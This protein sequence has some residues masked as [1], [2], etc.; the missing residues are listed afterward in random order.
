MPTRLNEEAAKAVDDRIAAIWEKI[1]SPDYFGK[2]APRSLM[3]DLFYGAKKTTPEALTGGVSGRIASNYIP[4]EIHEKT[5]IGI[6]FSSKGDA[7][8]VAATRRDDNGALTIDKIFEVTRK[9]KPTPQQD[10]TLSPQY[11][12]RL[13]RRGRDLYDEYSTEA[14]H[15]NPRTA[16]GIPVKSN[17]M[18]PYDAPCSPCEGSGSGGDEATYCPRCKGAG[19]TRFVGMITND[20]IRS[21]TTVP[22]ITLLTEALPK[23]FYP[24]FPEGLMP[25][26]NWR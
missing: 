8:V 10:M 16:F 24:S 1:G 23:K 3:Y 15:G 9:M 17:P 25:I 5:V 19:A 2:A 20:Y 11:M 14:L 6:D 18:F 7:S 4:D 12:E 26:P 21:F 13:T 22:E